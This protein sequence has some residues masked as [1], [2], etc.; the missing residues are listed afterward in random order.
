M[1]S[2]GRRVGS[3]TAH[4]LV[5]DTRVVQSGPS[6]DWD[7]AHKVLLNRSI[8]LAVIENGARSIAQDGLAYDRCMVGVVTSLDTQAL[9]PDLRIDTTKRLFGVLRT[10]VDVVLR[11]G[12][13]IL[14]AD[15]PQVVEMAELSDGQVIFYGRDP[16]NTALI[17]HLGHG[18][19]AVF[20]RGRDIVLAIG[21]EEAVLETLLDGVNVEA[22][23]PA[24]AVAWSL[25]FT[26]ELIRA[27]IAS[28]DSVNRVA[29]RA[30]VQP[31]LVESTL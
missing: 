4:G 10:Q 23:L 8:E 12:A 29:R 20:A 28:L 2:S 1:R 6:A 18:R 15:D 16:S 13:S 3:A 25:G 14:N 26:P 31:A 7:S 11:E 5:A 27:G 24:V 30:R 17:D 9:L 19:R 22:V 21:R